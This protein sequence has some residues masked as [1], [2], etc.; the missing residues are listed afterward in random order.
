MVEKKGL[1]KKNEKM[2]GIKEVKE[3]TA[4]AEENIKGKMGESKEGAMKKKEKMG[5]K[6]DKIQEGA[7]EKKEGV[8]TRRTQAEDIWSDI[9]GSFRDRQEEFGRALS[10][11]TSSQKPLTDVIET[12]DDI[13]IKVDLPGVKKEDINIGIAEDSVEVMAKFEEKSEVRDVNYIQKERTY[14]ETLRKVSLPA[15]VK[16]EETRGTF[17]DSILT[18]KMPKLEKKMHK[19]DIQ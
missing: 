16:T 7:V 13:I 11:Y 19:L 9:M 2:R 10:E 8:K 6:M 5:S 18:I 14:G 3:T 4:K 1:K 15:K 17:S 12:D